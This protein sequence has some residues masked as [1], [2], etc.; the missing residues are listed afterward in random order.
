LAESF[1]IGEPSNEVQS[2]LM[3]PFENGYFLA[4]EGAGFGTKLSTKLLERLN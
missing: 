2:A 1:G 3:P 4:P